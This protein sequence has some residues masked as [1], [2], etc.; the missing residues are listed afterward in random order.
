MSTLIQ[1]IDGPIV[2]TSDLERMTALYGVFG[3]EVVAENRLGVE[4]V[5]AL[6]G[7]DAR[8]ARSVLLETPGTEV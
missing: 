8:T 5:K 3:L 2:S 1:A 4:E 6:W 7:V